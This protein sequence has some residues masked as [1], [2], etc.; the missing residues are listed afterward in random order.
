MVS[1]TAFTRVGCTSVLKMHTMRIDV[2]VGEDVR[3]MI[4][5]HIVREFDSDRKWH[6]SIANQAFE[7]SIK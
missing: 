2:R 5:I 7:V 6:K 4:S 3:D 1:S